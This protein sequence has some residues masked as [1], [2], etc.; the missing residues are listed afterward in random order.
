M[1]F[2]IFFGLVERALEFG[3]DRKAAVRV[4]CDQA[5]VA[6]PRFLWCRA[7]ERG[8]FTGCV[9]YLHLHAV[10][11]DRVAEGA[12]RAVEGGDGVESYVF[13]LYVRKVVVVV[14]VDV[15]QEGARILG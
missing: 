11:I 3:G 9:Q 5:R 15:T 2:Y 4:D 8:V 13:D 1:F 10:P 12:D 6:F 14:V 7:F